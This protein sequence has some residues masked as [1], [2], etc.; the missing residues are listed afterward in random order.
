MR[1]AQ[2]L[3]CMKIRNTYKIFVGKGKRRNHSEVIGV[4]RIIILK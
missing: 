2:H 4:D 1:W 3:A